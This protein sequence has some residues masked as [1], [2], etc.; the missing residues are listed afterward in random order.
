[1]PVIPATWETEVGGSW[2]QAS[3][4]KRVRPY[5]KNKLKAKR[6]GRGIVQKKEY[7]SSKCGALSLIPRIAKKKKTKPN[8]TKQKAW[9]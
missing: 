1:M 6:T 4:G 7:L 3:L 8:K 5:L 2:Y 9:E